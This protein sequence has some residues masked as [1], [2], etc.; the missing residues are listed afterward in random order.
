M[1]G[2]WG[3][4][5]GGGVG[6]L[7]EDGFGGFVGVVVR[8]DEFTIEVFAVESVEKTGVFGCVV[9]IEDVS[10]GRVW[11]GE[12]IELGTAEYDERGAE[13]ESETDKEVFSTRFF[14]VISG[15]EGFSEAV[16]G[17]EGSE[18]DGEEEEG[19]KSRGETITIGD[20]ETVAGGEEV[21]EAEV[22]KAAFINDVVDIRDE[23]E[24]ER[25]EEE[26]EGG[27]AGQGEEESEEGEEEQ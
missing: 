21:G 13:A 9:C 25:C 26:G 15:F 23:E 19:M 4:V 7:S 3:G 10:D 20:T 14:E 8:R 24:D 17:D 27:A 22:D 1:G 6:I 12:E 18:E 16:E 5:L 11:T 2:L